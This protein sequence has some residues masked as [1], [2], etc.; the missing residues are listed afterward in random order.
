MCC[1]E[2]IGDFEAYNH[3]DMKELRQIPVGNA[4]LPEYAVFRERSGI[5]RALHMLFSDVESADKRLGK[6]SLWSADIAFPG[7]INNYNRRR[8][9]LGL[10]SD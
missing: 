5:D 9:E 2:L 4:V 1:Y 7:G 10:L 3:I 6:S 8:R